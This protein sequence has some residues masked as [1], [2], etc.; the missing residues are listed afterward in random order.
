MGGDRGAGMRDRGAALDAALAAY[1]AALQDWRGRGEEIAAEQADIPW[2][3]TAEELIQNHASDAARDVLAQW[4]R[5]GG[6]RSFAQEAAYFR[7][8]RQLRRE[9]GE[10]P[11]PPIP[12]DGGERR[13]ATDPGYENDDSRR[14]A[15]PEPSI[16]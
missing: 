14:N 16:E 4:H 11:P 10:T 9:L 15:E 8:E 3:T 5:P 6:I 1:D 12:L 7:D 2:E 13:P